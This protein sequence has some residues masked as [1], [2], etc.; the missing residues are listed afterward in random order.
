[1]EILAWKAQVVTKK[2]SDSSSQLSNYFHLA[3]VS[4]LTVVQTDRPVNEFFLL[5]YMIYI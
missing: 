3:V 5:S 4:D 2:H 1:M